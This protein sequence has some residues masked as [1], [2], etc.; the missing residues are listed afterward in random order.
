MNPAMARQ[1]PSGRKSLGAHQGEGAAFCSGY[2]ANLAGPLG[3]AFLQLSDRKCIKALAAGTM[4]PRFGPSCELQRSP[5]VVN[6]KKNNR[7]SEGSSV[8]D[9]CSLLCHSI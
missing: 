8:P 4:G 5:I 7:C 9:G 2:C 1:G 6:K 3:F